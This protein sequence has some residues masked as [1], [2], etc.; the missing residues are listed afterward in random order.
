MNLQKF[1]VD[2]ELYYSD[3]CLKVRKKE[4]GQGQTGLWLGENFVY[5]IRF[6]NKFNIYEKRSR[7]SYGMAHPTADTELVYALFNSHLIS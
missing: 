5:S 6:L 2:K 1:R 3:L 4:R 7:K